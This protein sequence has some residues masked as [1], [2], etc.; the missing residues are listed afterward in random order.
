MTTYTPNP[1]NNVN[2]YLA[3]PCNILDT[4]DD[5]YTITI[6]MPANSAF[7]SDLTDL[8]KEIKRVISFD[9]IV[10]KNAAGAIVCTN[11]ECADYVS[12]EQI[13]YSIKPLYP[14]R[15]TYLYE[16]KPK[17]AFTKNVSTIMSTIPPSTPPSLL[18]QNDFAIFR[19]T[20]D[21]SDFKEL[22][23]FKKL[24]DSIIENQNYLVMLN[25]KNFI[26]HNLATLQRI[27]K[28]NKIQTGT[29][30]PLKKSQIT[31]L[32]NG[33]AKPEKLTPRP[34][35]IGNQVRVSARPLS[36]GT[37]R[38]IQLKL[39]LGGKQMSMKPT[40]MMGFNQR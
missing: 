14:P 4:R 35:A 36:S 10:G 38:P 6:K 32:M 23:S 22:T 40:G 31:Q 8:M 29:L 18:S 1:K 24:Y 9:E 27:Q 37:P 7:P 33:T 30:V 25:E 21:L 19:I 15:S 39:Q 34:N 3:L 13:T 26:E 12:S 17:I 5:S 28:T 20:Y 16:Y 11:K 2:F